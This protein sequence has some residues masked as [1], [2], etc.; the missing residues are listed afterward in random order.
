MWRTDC[1][2]WGAGKGRVRHGESSVDTQ[3]AAA[4]AELLQSCLTLQ[5]ARLPGPW[6]SPGRSP[7]C[8]KIASGKLPHS[9][10]AQFCAI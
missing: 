4:V 1:G 9:K 2:W 6:D 10:D 5:P 8:C 3:A 7:G